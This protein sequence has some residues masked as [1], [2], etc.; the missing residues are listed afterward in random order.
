MVGVSHLVHNEVAYANENPVH[1]ASH[2]NR[3][4]SQ[5]WVAQIHDRKQ[6]FRITRYSLC[7]TPHL[8]HSDN[9]I[10]SAL[11][12]H[13]ITGLVAQQDNS[14]RPSLRQLHSLS[15]PGTGLIALLI[16]KLQDASHSVMGTRI[17][18]CLTAFKT[19][20]WLHGA[21]QV[22]L[23]DCRMPWTDAM[24]TQLAVCRGHTAEITC[25]HLTRS[26][27]LR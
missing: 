16:Q 24:G 25:C 23:W 10:R 27:R 9:L 1:V 7:L 15:S 2:S 20:R 19:L 5:S 12:L 17:S 21:L 6:D 4:A 13:W 26:V 3:P 14:A 8:P 18:V 22:R 11:L